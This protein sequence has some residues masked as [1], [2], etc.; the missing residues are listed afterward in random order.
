[1]PKKLLIFDIDGT[2]CNINQPIPSYLLE[3]LQEVSKEHQVVL[4]SGKPF[5]YIAGLI[6]QLGLRNCMAIGENGGTIM[7]SATFPP[8]SYYQIEVSD[9]VQKIF[10]EIKQQYS[11]KFAQT[12]WFQPNDVN[13][14][15]FPLDIENIEQIHGFAK[16]FECDEINTYYHR[17]SVDFTPKG[18]DKGIAVD[19]L[20]EKLGFNRSELYVF[21]DGSNDLPMLLKT[22]NSFLINTKLYGFEPKEYFS[23]YDALAQFLK[24]LK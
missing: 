21:G 16:Q 22:E 15:V 13:L 24:N 18:F 12:I 7:Y 5:G 19:I 8:T 10:F 20:L 3:M 11:K 9:V 1:M 4:A 14:T 23:D 2:L 6:R 17:D